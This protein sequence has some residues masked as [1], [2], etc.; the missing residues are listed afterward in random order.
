MKNLFLI[1]AL[2]PCL[3]FASQTFVVKDNHNVIIGYKVMDGKETKFY[4]AHNV[5]VGRC[6]ADDNQKRT[7]CYDKHNREIS[8]IELK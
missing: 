1:L 7:I 4:D 3:A 2:I 8:R 5:Y 6:K